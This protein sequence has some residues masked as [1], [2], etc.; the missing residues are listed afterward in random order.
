[1]SDLTFQKIFWLFLLGSVL[2]VFVE[3]FWCLFRYGK[4]ETHTVAMWGPFNIVYGIGVPMFYLGSILVAGAHWLRRFAAHALIGSLVEYLCG[5]VIRIGVQ[6]K[7][8]D[9]SDHTMNIRGLISPKMT[10]VW[11]FAGLGFN[12]FL[13]SPL[14]GLLSLVTGAFWDFVCV[15]LTVFMIINLSLTAACIIRWSNRH[16]GKSA[17]NRLTKWIDEVYPDSKMARKFFYWSFIEPERTT[18]IDPS[19]SWNE[20]YL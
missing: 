8:W 12:L 16:R 5:I 3:G 18:Q 15:L 2:G 17:A 6:M 10:L 14:R 13:Y 4:W 7:A 11:G 19:N 9:Y 1:M 20:E